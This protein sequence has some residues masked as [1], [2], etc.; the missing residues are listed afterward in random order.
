MI[1]LTIVGIVAALTIPVLVSDYKEKT[2]VNRLKNSYAILS[3]AFQMAIAENGTVNG[4][5]KEDELFT[6]CSNRI[7]EKVEPYLRIS[8]K[9]KTY[10]KTCLASRHGNRFN[11]HLDN[12]NSFGPNFI[13]SDGQGIVI[14]AY[15]GENDKSRWCLA[16]TNSSQGLYEVGSGYRA[17]GFCAYIYVDI[18]GKNSPNVYDQDLFIFKLYRNGLV[19]QGLQEDSNGWDF[20]RYCLGKD[21]FGYCSGWVIFNGNME[22]LHCDDL[23]WTGKKSCN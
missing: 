14:R 3:S 2:T 1:T 18:N 5:C 19:P 9:C 21:R 17:T 16:N 13:L 4:W 6:E 7:F 23:S 8:E 12:V 22:Y 10:G 15:A 11:D 20:E